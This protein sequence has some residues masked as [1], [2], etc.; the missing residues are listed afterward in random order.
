MNWLIRQLQSLFEWLWDGL[1]KLFEWLVDSLGSVITWVCNHVQTVVVAGIASLGGVMPS[2]TL[3][4]TFSDMLLSATW[5]PPWGVWV[6]DR[7]CA[8]PE[9]LARLSYFGV[10]VLATYA[11]RALFTGIR[12]ALDLF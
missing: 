11:V 8:F 3:S 4:G 9:L 12:A 2:Q 5:V 7:W 6:M 1:L 10:V